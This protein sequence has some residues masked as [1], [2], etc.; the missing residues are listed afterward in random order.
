MLSNAP[1]A[2]IGRLVVAVVIFLVIFIAT[3]H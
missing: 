2:W 1:R 3:S